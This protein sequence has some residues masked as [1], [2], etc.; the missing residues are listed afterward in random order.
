MKL[1]LKQC[2]WENPSSHTTHQWRIR[3]L[4]LS[5]LLKYLASLWTRI[6]LTSLMW[7]LCPKKLMLKLRHCI[8]KATSSFKCHDQL[9]QSL[10]ATGLWILFSTAAGDFGNIELQT[11]MCQSLCIKIYFKLWELSRLQCL[12]IYQKSK[13]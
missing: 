12:P 13:M 8:D 3:S 9:I 1:R 2:L 6:C 7:I 5:V 11:W 4:G 10:R